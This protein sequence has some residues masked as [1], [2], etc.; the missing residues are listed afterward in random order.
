MF[1]RRSPG[2]LY[3]CRDERGRISKDEI[4]EITAKNKQ[5]EKGN[6]GLNDPSLLFIVF[7]N[8]YKI[9]ESTLTY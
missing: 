3:L 7:L 1:L 6:A 9:W 4:Q 5:P 2:K 8:F